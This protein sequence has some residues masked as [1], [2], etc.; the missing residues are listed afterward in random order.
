MTLDD[1]DPS[2]YNKTTSQS[3]ESSRTI[4]NA[5]ATWSRQLDIG[6]H[7]VTINEWAGLYLPAKLD[8][9]LRFLDLLAEKVPAFKRVAQRRRRDAV[10]RL[11]RDQYI[12]PWTRKD[13][14]KF[15]TEKRGDLQLGLKDVEHGFPVA[16]IQSI[17]L[18]A[19]EAGDVEQ[20]RK[21]LLYCWLIPTIHCTHETHRALPRRCG[22][23][24]RPLERYS[25][26]HES[27]RRL[28]EERYHGT[29]LT[30][31]R[32]DG[33]IID[34]D[35]YSRSQMLE[36][37]RSIDHLRPIVDGLDGLTLP[38]PEEEREYTKIMTAVAK[39]SNTGLID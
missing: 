30:L 33:V 10:G 21:R 15:F 23:F 25:E 28:A 8:A 9:D 19:L 2:E 38:S 34:P 1:E 11:A 24:E 27:L 4:V 14:P 20:A 22:D 36:D 31:R 32:F 16:Q 13:K 39:R 29:P 26:R 18:M 6:W 12:L 5:R 35:Q 37:L 17:V 7:G 3:E